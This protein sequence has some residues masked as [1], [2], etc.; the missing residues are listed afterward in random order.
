LLLKR[1]YDDKDRA[2]VDC[3]V[4]R[5]RLDHRAARPAN[6]QARNRLLPRPHY[7]KGLAVRRD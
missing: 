7:V 5:A 2:G 3:Q 1:V 4:L 6:G